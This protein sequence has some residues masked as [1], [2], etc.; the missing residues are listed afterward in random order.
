MLSYKEWV[1][2]EGG[3]SSVKTQ[4]I[5]ITPAILKIA[6][7]YVK[8]LFADFEKWMK[9]NHPNTLPLKGIRPVGSGIY[10]EEDLKNEPEKIYGDIDY[11]IEYPVYGDSTDERKTETEA[12][13]FYNREL[14]RF[15]NETKYK[16]IDLKDSRGADGSGAVLIAEVQ[17]NVYIQVDFVVTHAKYVDWA[18]D[19]FTPIHNIK[20]FVSGNLYS[21]LADAL[22]ISMGDRGARAK[23][24]AGALVPFRMRKDVEEIA[25]SLNFKTL[26]TDIV[27]FF[28][29]LKDNTQNPAFLQNDIAGIDSKN[30]SLAGIAQGIASLAEVLER[31][32]VLDGNTVSFKSAKELKKAV[33]VNYAK[34]MAE[35]RNDSKFQKAE[36]PMAI[37]ARDKIFKTSMDA[38]KEVNSI[39][40]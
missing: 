15:F 36:D 4:G 38:E 5:K 37:A 8:Q 26:F 25:I 22:S 19:R 27:N 34:K 10:Y 20:G 39:L 21:S 9:K 24:Q 30:L 31:N 1:L 7:D 2:N 14:F 23:L 13:R 35:L 11:L 40:G 17:P 3:W 28:V 33:A 16:G 12:I 32:G 6:D 18:L 29:S